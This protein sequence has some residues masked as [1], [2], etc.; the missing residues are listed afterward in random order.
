MTHPFL[1]FYFSGI[2]GERMIT[3][4][5]AGDLTYPMITPSIRRQKQILVS[6]RRLKKLNR[7]R[8]N[9]LSLSKKNDARKL[10]RTIVEVLTRKR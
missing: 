2:E 9:N 4:D 5:Y 10:E 8:F 3:A 6:K 1:L 7:Q